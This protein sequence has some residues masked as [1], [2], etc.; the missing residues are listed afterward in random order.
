M[1]DAF[2]GKIRDAAM[3]M[4]IHTSAVYFAMAAG[5]I[6][7]GLL[8]VVIP[9][10]GQTSNLLGRLLDSPF[11][12]TQVIC[13]AAAGWLVR[14]RFN[15]LNAGYGILFPLALLVLDILIEG[16]P[17]R[18]FVPLIDIY[19]S[20]NSG[21]TEGLYKLFFTA[22]VYTAIAY[23]IGALFV[24]FSKREEKDQNSKQPSRA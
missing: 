10:A 7:A 19:F 17:M 11:W 20:A 2:V 16:L 3:E 9:A 24:M 1:K 5:V 14:R 22:P 4:A 12:I 23:C 8:I 13:G 15:V 21:D 18:K 6:L